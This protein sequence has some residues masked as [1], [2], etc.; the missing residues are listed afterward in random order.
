MRTI[1]RLLAATCT[2]LIASNAVAG[3]KILDSERAALDTFYSRT[4]GD[5]WTVNTRWEGPAGTECTWEGITCADGDV[6]ITAIRL[7]NHNLQGSLPDL[8]AFNAL[9]VFDVQGNQLSGSVPSIVALGNLQ[10]FLVANNNFSGD[11]PSPPDGDGMQDGASSLCPNRFVPASSPQTPTDRFW[12]EATGNDPWSRG[13]T[14]A[15]VPVQTPTALPT[16]GTLS[17]FALAGLLGAVAFRR[18]LN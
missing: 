11:V 18:R 16:L 6:R 7:S 4:H 9:Q 14:A 2:A 17:L 5:A 15:V 8:S 13:C 1:H 3:A 10:V 12:D